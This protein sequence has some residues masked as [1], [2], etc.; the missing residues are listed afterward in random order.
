[1]WSLTIDLSVT[2][3]EYIRKNIYVRMPNLNGAL[4]VKYIKYIS[5]IDA[6]IAKYRLYPRYHTVPNL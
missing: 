4:R 1:M 5:N 2:H 6:S 3:N